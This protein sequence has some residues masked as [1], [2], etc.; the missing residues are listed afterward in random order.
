MLNNRKVFV[1]VRADGGGVWYAL[2]LLCFIGRHLGVN[3]E[4]CYVRWLHS[5]R[6]VA[7]AEQRDMTDEERR[8]PFPTYRWARQPRNRPVGH[9]AA[10]G[11]HYGVLEASGVLYAAP[12][13]TGLGESPDSDDPLFRLNVDMWAM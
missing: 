2:L 12:I 4:F 10:N 13:M 1:A 8:G 3:R 9:P 6:A 11:P 5:A 7:H